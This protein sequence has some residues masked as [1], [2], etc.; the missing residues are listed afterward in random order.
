MHSAVMYS[1]AMQY[2]KLQ[3]STIVLS[4]MEIQNSTAIQTTAEVSD[5]LSDISESILLR[6]LG[7]SLKIRCLILNKP[8]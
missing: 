7:E 6:A 8:V 4:K 5:L 1:A 2:N 3:Y